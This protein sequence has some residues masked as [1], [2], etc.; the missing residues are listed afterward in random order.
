MLNS[1]FLFSVMTLALANSNMPQYEFVEEWRLWKSQHSRS[2]ESEIEELNRHLVWLSNKKFIELHNANSHVFGFTLAMNHFGDL[3]SI[4]YLFFPS[5]IAISKLT[6]SYNV[7]WIMYI[8]FDVFRLIWNGVR[9]TAR[10][11]Q[12]Q[13]LEITPSSTS[14]IP[15]RA[16]P[17]LS[18]GGPKELS[19]M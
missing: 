5:Y 8:F 17:N 16:I 4:I 1:I 6:E 11:P 9:N 12:C 14:Q 15:T 3:V 7:L 2:Y 19:L 10:T 13:I 18:T